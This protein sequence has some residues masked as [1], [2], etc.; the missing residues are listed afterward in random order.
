MKLSKEK[1]EEWCG[2]AREGAIGAGQ[3]IQSQADQ[4][5]EIRHKAGGDSLASQ[6]VTSVDIQAQRLIL[7]ALHSTMKSCELGVLTEESSD[8]GSRADQPYFWCIDPMDGTLPFSERRS[9]YAVS[10]ALVSKAG[11]PVI[12]VVYIPDLEECYTSVKGMGLRLNGQPL[13]RPSSVAHQ[14]DWYMDRSLQSENYFEQV[15]AD[16]LKWAGEES[17][18]LHADFGGVRNAIGAITAQRGCYFKFPKHRRG[19]GSIWDYAA[20]RLFAEEMNL[21]VCDVYGGRLQLNDPETTFMNKGGVVYATDE[22]L[23]RFIQNLH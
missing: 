6:V 20:T 16:F 21:C 2:I 23:V 11:D 7:Q 4:S 3:Y 15:K 9:G 18:V 12:G 8:D 19:C 13:E 10:I 22:E 5:F 17:L 1:L 14:I